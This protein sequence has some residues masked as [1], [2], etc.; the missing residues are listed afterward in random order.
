MSRLLAIVKIVLAASAA[1]PM[2]PATSLAQTEIG[3]DA[4]I[5]TT[6]GSGGHVTTIAIPSA[7]IRV[8][9]YIS[10]M[11][12][13]E[14]RIGLISASGG[15]GSATIYATSLSALLHFGGTAAGLG[16]YLRPFAGIRGYTGSGSGHQTSVGVGFG[17]TVNIVSELAGRFEANFGH[18]FASATG[19]G[20]SGNVIGA[21]IG[22]SYFIR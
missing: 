17:T 20:D 4:T 2:V 5:Q 12:S 10:P 21:N 13:L 18:D 11:V 22:L 3:T 7:S 9:F 16:P 1:I 15:G 8:G 6:L 19:A 14:P